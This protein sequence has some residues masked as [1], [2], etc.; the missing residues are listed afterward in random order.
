MLY[1]YF[2]FIINHQTSPATC[3]ILGTILGT[4]VIMPGEKLLSESACKSAKPKDKVYYLNDGKGLRLRVRPD[5]SRTWIFRYRYD[6]KE[7]NIGLGPYP[8]VT[9][10][11]ARTKA[12]QNR[13]IIA[14]GKNPSVEK[15]AA[16]TK[17][18]IKNSHTFGV[19]A[20]EWIEHNKDTWSESHLE[21]NQG[22]LRRYLLP[23]LGRLPI[24]TIDEQL[25]FDVLRPIYD[26]GVKE[27]ARR[28]RVIAAQIFSFGRSTQRC[29]DNPAKAM[30]DNS[31]FKRPP[32]KHFSAI[33]QDDVPLLVAELKKKDGKQRLKPQTVCALFLAMYTGLR[34]KSIRGAKWKEI[35]F[36]KELWTVPA[37]RMKSRR[38]HE[39][40]L[41]DQAISALKNLQPITDKGPESFIF[42]AAT[43][44]GFI[45]E[46]TLR[47][48]LHRLGF[49]VTVHGFRSLITDV[50]NENEFNADAIEKQLDHKEKNSVRKAYL[51]SEFMAKR[52]DMMQ[53]FANWCER[54]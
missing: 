36:K 1:G 51:R 17:Q 18:L 19:I 31:Y 2:F 32:I 7:N 44:S 28:S 27:S 34:D 52:K 29:I 5:G 53:W 40:P 49:K 35:D 46:N 9:I 37:H 25:L 42:A 11:V 38:Q 48:A 50:L 14:L 16:K 23:D 47:L 4:E 12:E 22:L 33:A 20:K 30:S 3:I 15:K 26:K 41:P 21:R 45:A 39:V 8:Q 10:K 24:T 43:K 54:K 13:Q 6:L